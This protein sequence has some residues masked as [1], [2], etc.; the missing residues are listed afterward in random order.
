MNPEGNKDGSSK[1][2][3]A[4]KSEAERLASAEDSPPRTFKR[5]LLDALIT[6]LIAFL[7]AVLVQS[8]L[9][10][11]FIIP[12][13]SMSPT[14]QVGDR[15]LAEKL[16]YYWRS[17]RRGD[18]IIFR[19]PPESEDSLE[20]SNPLY[21]PFERIG[22][23]LHLAHKSSI[24]YVKRVVAVEGET[25]ELRDG[26]LYVDNVKR[27]ESYAVRDNDNYGPL[28]VGKGEL[29]C[30]GDNRSNSRDSR[31][32][33]MVNVRSVIGRVFLIWWPTSRIQKPA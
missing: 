7:I 10:S 11:G 18:I 8:F 14:L 22:E 20:T 13:S 16:S 12:S 25:V 5:R 1:E 21:R 3:P 19:Y 2:A 9:V 28:K 23:T 4:A 24:A 27:E 26:N 30:L 17:P 32:W 6:L 29:F 15:V 33:G 31:V